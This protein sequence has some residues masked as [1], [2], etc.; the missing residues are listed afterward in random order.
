MTEPL[1]IKLKFFLHC[2]EAFAI[3]LILLKGIGGLCANA[4]RAATSAGFGWR[5]FD[6]IKTE[7]TR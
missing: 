4:F 2:S 7:K 6:F 3:S 1:F 5:M